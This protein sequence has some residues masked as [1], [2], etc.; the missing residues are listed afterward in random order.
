[1]VSNNNV[2]IVSGNSHPELALAIAEN[3]GISVTKILSVRLNNREN[4]QTV[5]ESIKGCHVFIVQT[6]MNSAT[7]SINDNFMELLQLINTCKA[8]LASKIIAVLPFFPYSRQDKKDH[9]RV[10]ITAKLVA[11]LL[12]RAG[13]DRIITI[14]LHSDQIC[15][16]FNIPVEN[17]TAEPILNEAIL[18]EITDKGNTIFVTPDAGGAKRCASIA[19]MFQ[20]SISFF[21]KGNHNIYI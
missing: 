9:T 11:S 17:L 4:T 8:G 15:G 20:V 5:C 6:N 14:D 3:L 7:S 13:V 1:M 18:G 12:E 19:E 10:P 2:K 21:H 16:F